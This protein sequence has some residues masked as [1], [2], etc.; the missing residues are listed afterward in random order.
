[1]KKVPCIIN[2]AVGSWFPLAQQRLKTSLDMVGYTGDTL[3][4]TTWPPGSP[5]H[6]EAPYAF[7]GFAIDAARKLG[8]ELIL[9]LDSSIWAVRQFPDLFKYINTNGYLFMSNGNL[10]MWSSD[11]A[12]KHF[13]VD[14][15]TALTMREVVGGFVGLNFKNKNCNDFLDEW[16]ALAKDTKLF[17]GSWKNDNHEV[18]SDSRVKGHRHDQTVTSFL[19]Y[20]YGMNH[21]VRDYFFCYL[22]HFSKIIRPNY[23]FVCQG[24]LL[25]EDLTY[26]EKITKPMDITN[27]TLINTPPQTVDFDSIIK[28]FIIK[29]DGN[30]GVRSHLPAL[31]W[32]F[33]KQKI[34]TVFEFGCGNHSTDLFVTTCNK[35]ESY[36]M[37]SEQWYKDIL[38]KYK[39][40]SNFILKFM[41]G[42]DLAIEHLKQQTAKYDLIFVDGHGETR[43]KA[44]NIA[45]D[46]TDLIVVHDTEEGGYQWWKIEQPQNWTRIEVK[47]FP[48]WTTIFFKN[49][50]FNI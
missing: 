30:G 26:V 45:F 17:R 10:G 24:G 14:R 20:K 6:N 33:S 50:T 19:A 28:E 25:P 39:E 3:F 43:W 29:Q 27:M 7:K 38:A 21:I 47:I 32:V 8:Y 37:Q 44:V 31:R 9:Y 49:G 46:K 13:G 41:L 2:V 36:E 22:N 15:E 1:M 5:T 40:K 12:I 18:S 34:N 48:V 42:P 23:Q 4:F 16:L 11:E 35:V